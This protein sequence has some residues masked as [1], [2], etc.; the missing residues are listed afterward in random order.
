MS[1]SIVVDMNLSVEWVPVFVREGWN[2]VHWSQVGDPTAEDTAIMAWAR[3]NQHV[4]FT[5]DLD[6]TT[7]LALTHAAGPSVVQV[8]GQ[9]VLPD[10]IGPVV[11]AAIRGHEQELEQGALLTVDMARSRLRVLPL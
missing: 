1:L 4:V 5:H 11:V 2:T 10:Q 7:V 9:Q 8:R 3:A 6:F